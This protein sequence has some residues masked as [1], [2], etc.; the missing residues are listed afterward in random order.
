MNLV[1]VKPF[2][3][4]MLNGETRLNVSMH[5]SL[6]VQLSTVVMMKEELLGFSE[7]MVFVQS[8]LFQ[9]ITKNGNLQNLIG[10]N[11]LL[12]KCVWL[13]YYCYKLSKTDIFFS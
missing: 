1:Q 7:K 8:K 13:N 6:I 4:A 5:M 3:I 11:M 9:R 2:F 12:M 10:I